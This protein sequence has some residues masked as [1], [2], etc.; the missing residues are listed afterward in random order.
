MSFP[1]PSLR[2][3]SEPVEVTRTQY[4][5]FPAS[6]VRRGRPVEVSA[7]RRCWTSVRRDLAGRLNE[8]HH[9]RVLTAEGAFVLTHDVRRN[10]W[11]LAQDLEDSRSAA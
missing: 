8:Q 11:L 4:Q 5:Y 3:S 1:F 2:A 6:F 9:F 7:V 10:R